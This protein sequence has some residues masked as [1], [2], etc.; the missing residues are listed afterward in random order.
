MNLKFVSFIAALKIHC[1]KEIVDNLETIGGYFLEERGLV[2]MKGKG[3]LLT[4]WLVGQIDSY[5]REKPLTVNYAD[6]DDAYE[7]RTSKYLSMQG[8]NERDSFSGSGRKLETVPET[9]SQCGGCPKGR[10][11]TTAL[12]RQHTAF[13]PS[14]RKRYESNMQNCVSETTL[15]ESVAEQE[16]IRSELT[17]TNGL[18]LQSHPQ[19]EVKFDEPNKKRYSDTD[20][21]FSIPMNACE[22]ETIV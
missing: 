17:N 9:W 8:V 5:K 15:P 10:S 1:S 20:I 6:Q 7:K 22:T 4:Y 14:D 11:S 12:N 19:H 16:L 2:N 18:K 3:E 21:T 13:N